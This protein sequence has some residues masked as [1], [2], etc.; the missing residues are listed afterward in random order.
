[1][2]ILDDLLLA[3]AKGLLFI[4]KEIYKQVDKELYDETHILKQLRSL[5]TSLEMDEITEEEY[6]QAEEKLMERL[7]IA[8]ERNMETSEEE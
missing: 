5:Q 1:M 7:Q 2:F 4:F 6:D 8:R 3:P